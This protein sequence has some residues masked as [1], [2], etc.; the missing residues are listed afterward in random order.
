[1]WIDGKARLS[2][3]FT[4][5][6]QKAG[7]WAIFPIDVGRYWRE[8]SVMKWKLLLCAACLA[9]AGCAS[10]NNNAY[11]VY[12]EFGFSYDLVPPPVHGLSTA[13][14]EQMYGTSGVMAPVVYGQSLTPTG[15]LH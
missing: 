4:N 9:M 5:Y 10:E 12:G 7:Q 13:D 15:T 11:A 14:L 1:V 2:P 6:P 8:Y 3:F